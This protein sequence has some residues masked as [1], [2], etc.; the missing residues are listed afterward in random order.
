MTGERTPMM[1][2]LNLKGTNLNVSRTCFGTM[3]FGGQVD[4]HAASTM[5]DYCLDNEI[6]FFDTANIYERGLSEEFLGKALR[7]KRKSIVLAS[8]VRGKMGEGSD[9]RGLS[10]LAI[11]KAVEASLK[12][13]QT[14]YLDIYYLHQPD[15]EVPLEETLNTMQELVSSG[16]VR[17]P[18]SSNFASWQ[19]GQMLCL[20]QEKKYQPAVIAQQMY[21]VLARGLEQE[22]IPMARERGVSLV[23][24]NPLAGGLLTAKHQA[25]L[26]T[27]ATRFDKNSMYQDR[28]WWPQNF[29][30]VEQLQA[31]A[32]AAG[33]SLISL[34]L[35][36]LLHHTPVDCVILGASTLQQLE[37]N[38]AALEEGPLTS[39][40]LNV[41]D[42]VWRDLRGPSPTYN[43]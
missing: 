31:A 1:S 37:Q 10:R 6:N 38:R 21:N 36:W 4:Q 28:Y 13:L 16:K 23:A 8:K 42:E 32:L 11:I 15:Y 7:G 9:E 43:R 5:I 18:A 2:Y 33:R 14:D 3:T 26:F 19:V 24:Y 41:C 22:F 35:N 17:Y 12:R 34:S 39:E 30:A 40:L 25:N 29:R 20:A 27:P